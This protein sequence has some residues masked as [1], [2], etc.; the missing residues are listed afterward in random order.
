MP[1]LGGGRSPGHL[2]YMSLLPHETKLGKEALSFSSS[3][4]VLRGT[5]NGPAFDIPS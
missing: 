1:A 5:Q 4:M 2:N 3:G